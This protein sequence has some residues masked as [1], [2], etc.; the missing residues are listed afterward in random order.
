MLHLW[1]LV[2]NQ[3][4]FAE[5]S[6]LHF[7]NLLLQFWGA[8]LE[9]FQFFHSLRWTYFLRTLSWTRLGRAVIESNFL[10]HLLSA[11]TYL[12]LEVRNRLGHGRLSIV[13]KSKRLVA[14]GRAELVF[15]GH[16]K[17]F[18]L[19]L[20]H[21]VQWL[22]LCRVDGIKNILEGQMEVLLA[23]SA[24]WGDHMFE[25]LYVLL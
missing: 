11:V 24:P 15:G 5:N 22:H 12:S 9:L 25:A 3:L 13:P 18:V 21:D 19:F 23:R 6:L 20:T 1:I 4:V 2:L 16:L 14:E 8:L 10:L 7:R 17:H